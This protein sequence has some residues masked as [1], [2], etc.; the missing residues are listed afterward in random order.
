MEKKRNIF[1]PV[2]KKYYGFYNS[3]SVFPVLIFITLFI[4]L[5][6]IGLYVSIGDTRVDLGTG[7]YNSGFIEFIQQL[8][9]IIEV[10]NYTVSKS[11][12]TSTIIFI[13]INCLVGLI[14]LTFYSKNDART[15]F[16][17]MLN[18]KKILSFKERGYFN[19]IYKSFEEKY[20]RNSD[21]SYTYGYRIN[22]DLDYSDLS[23]FEREQYD[24]KLSEFF[25]FCSEKQ[26]TAT[27]YVN[28]KPFNVEIP[29]K[30]DNVFI[31]DMVKET[32]IS[33][34]FFVK[35]NN[36]SNAEILLFVT[37]FT[38]PDNFDG[39]I[40]NE[41]NLILSSFRPT[42][43]NKNEI[44]ENGFKINESGIKFLDDNN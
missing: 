9:F 8:F 2:I 25:L 18:R 43:I 29:I 3:Y 27:F 19:G 12:P 11:I 13:V 33:Q 7:E 44:I 30:T 32:N 22:F 5:G 4:F 34:A 35:K 37:T 36:V 20:I 28:K 1:Y 38:V 23:E 17:E 40:G 26:V 16:F 15:F 39:L 41:L 10:N 42:R 31:Q 24:K 14:S 6:I 21:N